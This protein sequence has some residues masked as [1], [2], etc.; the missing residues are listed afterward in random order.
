LL[1]LTGCLNERGSVDADPIR[2]GPSIPAR[3]PAPGRGDSGGGSLASSANEVPPLPPP[4]TP[5][6]PAGLASGD[7]R[8]PSP[9]KGPGATLRPPTPVVTP[10]GPGTV[11]NAAPPPGAPPAPAVTLTAGTQAGPTAPAPAPALPVSLPTASYEQLQGMLAARNVTWQRLEMVGDQGEWQF[12][13]AIPNPANRIMRRNY[14]ARAVGPYGLAAIRAAIAEIDMVSGAVPRPA[15]APVVVTP[16]APAAPTVTPAAPA[17][18]GFS[19]S[20][21]R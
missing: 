9:N 10:L 20:G 16:V 3:A 12:M 6:S 11:V 13:C 8:I 7:L 17:T 18:A 4:Y 15:V 5:S 1:L 21:A 19:S 2:G 14:V